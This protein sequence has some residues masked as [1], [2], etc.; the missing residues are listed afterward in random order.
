MNICTVRLNTFIKVR[1]LT[2]KTMRIKESRNYCSRKLG[3]EINAATLAVGVSGGRAH[4]G[5]SMKRVVPNCA[6]RSEHSVLTSSGV[7][8]RRTPV[9]SIIPKTAQRS[10]VTLAT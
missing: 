1:K 4:P 7:P 3:A 6:S 8:E 9:G 2:T 10:F 5:P